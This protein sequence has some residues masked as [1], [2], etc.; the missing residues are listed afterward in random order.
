MGSTWQVRSITTVAMLALAAGGGLAMAQAPS[1]AGTGTSTSPAAHSGERTASA[2][3]GHSGS[4]LSKTDRTFVRKAAEG[5]LA[6]VQLGQLAQQQ[7]E[8][9]AVKEFG[10]RMVTDHQAA[11]EKLQTIAQN[12]QLQLPTTLSR[13]DEKE[14]TKLQ[15]LHGAAF[16]RAY[17]RDMR[18]DHR[19]DIREFEHEAKHGKNAELKQ[20]ADSTLST[21]KGH[22]ASA[23]KLKS[24][25]REASASHAKTNPATR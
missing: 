21:L 23:E 5:G 13:H 3:S 18:S 16:D 22:L 1:A 15:G 12:E 14:L 24:S 9:D 17:S 11:N 2:A 10:Q 8:S 6:E 19:S 25:N 4:A 7:G 20:F